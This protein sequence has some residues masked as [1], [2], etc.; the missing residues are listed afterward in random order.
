M[1]G[2]AYVPG[3]IVS[4][5][6]MRKTKTPYAL[7]CMVTDDVTEHAREQLRVVFDE[8]VVI[9]YIRERC[10][11]LR[12]R[13]QQKIYEDW[14]G[15]AFTK[16]Q[17]LSLVQYNKVLFVDADKII[18]SNVDHIFELPTP[19][20][21]F[22]SPWAWPYKKP[23][24][25]NPYANVQ[26]GGVIEPQMLHAG[27]RNDG[28]VC[29]GTFVLLHP[30]LRHLHFFRKM[31]AGHAKADPTNPGFGFN[32]HSMVD[33]QS[34]VRSYYETKQ[35]W[36]MID[37]RYQFIPWHTDWIK[38]MQEPNVIPFLCHY[39][40]SK[41]WE[42]PRGDYLDMEAWWQLAAAMVRDTNAYSKEQIALLKEMFEARYLAEEPVKV[43]KFC[44]DQ[45]L[46]SAHYV[47]NEVGELVCP[48]LRCARPAPWH[49]ERWKRRQQRKQQERQQQAQQQQQQQQQQQP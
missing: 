44:R 25:N 2:D 37:Q 8:V 47:Y 31:L 18:F 36:H 5:Y 30:S 16:W 39:F 22:T 48:R 23:G 21:S 45:N 33:E 14:V 42:L 49:I 17:A 32:C 43:C 28:I 40:S 41:P 1:K 24:I 46:P 10:R 26:H 38:K 7:V 20:G 9:E 13:K 27:F 3:A 19:A 6:S 11:Q 35:P 34:I 29:I 15:E 4:A 12:T